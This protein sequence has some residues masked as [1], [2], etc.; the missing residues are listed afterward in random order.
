[1]SRAVALAALLLL[2]ALAAAPLAAADSSAESIPFAKEVAGG[3]D[4]AKSAGTQAAAAVAGG[5]TQPVDPDP[6]SGIKADP[7]PARR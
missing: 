2:A 5:A 1:M 4:A 6:S 7:A 3:A